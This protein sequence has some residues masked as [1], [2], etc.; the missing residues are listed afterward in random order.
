[1]ITYDVNKY[2]AF[3]TKMAFYY[4]CTLYTCFIDSCKVFDRINCWTLFN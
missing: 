2:N 3:E 1:M 4:S